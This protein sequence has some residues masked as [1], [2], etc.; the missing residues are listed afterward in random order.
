MTWSSVM[1]IYRE[2]RKHVFHKPKLI[3]WKLRILQEILG[4]LV[5]ISILTI[6]LFRVSRPKCWNK[7]MQNGKWLRYS[8]VS[9]C[10]LQDSHH[11]GSSLHDESRLDS[12]LC[13]SVITWILIII[14]FL[15]ETGE[16]EFGRQTYFL[17]TVSRGRMRPSVHFPK[18]W[19][20]SCSHASLQGT[21]GL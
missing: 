10:P 6:V 1:N 18:A 5:K 17:C 21:W 12:Y 19:N 15:M 13:A 3:N 20:K 8:E 14:C 16:R 7:W 4:N 11:W 2:S 9:H